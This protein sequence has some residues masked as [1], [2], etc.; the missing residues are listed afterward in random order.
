MG[1]F[2]LVISR[3]LNCFCLQVKFQAENGVDDG[4][5]SLEFF[6]LLGRE[7]LIMEPKT[8]EVYESGLA[9]FTTD[10]CSIFNYKLFPDLTPSFPTILFTKLEI[11]IIRNVYYYLL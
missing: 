8:L 2:R 7:L 1:L 10:V 3:A 11:S 5:V 9:W 4:G 6:R